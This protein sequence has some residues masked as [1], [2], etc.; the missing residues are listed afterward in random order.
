MGAG[1]VGRGL[2]RLDGQAVLGDRGRGRRGGG[3]RGR[4]VVGG[5]GADGVGMAVV[6][7]DG[8]ALVEG[9]DALGGLGG[10]HLPPAA[11]LLRLLVHGCGPLRCRLLLIDTRQAARRWQ[12]VAVAVAGRRVRRARAAR[13]RQDWRTV[14]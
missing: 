14:S 8:G 9:V 13:A 5:D 12:L 2:E 1:A 10:A 3:L 11:S 7:A 6:V 4:R